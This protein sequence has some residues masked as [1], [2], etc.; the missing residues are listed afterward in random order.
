M[1]IRSSITTECEALTLPLFLRDILLLFYA[2]HM[3]PNSLPN[4]RRPVFPELRQPLAN[5]RKQ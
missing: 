2:S 3:P 5:V 4:E 1:M